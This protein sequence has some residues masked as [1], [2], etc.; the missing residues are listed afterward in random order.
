MLKDYFDFE[1]RENILSAEEQIGKHSVMAP[2]DYR[3]PKERYEKFYTP[4]QLSYLF[5]HGIIQEYTPTG[6][7]WERSWMKKGDYYE[8]TEY[9]KKLRIWYSTSLKDYLYYYVLKLWK[10]KY[11]WQ[12]IMIKFGK[13]Y[14]WQEYA[15]LDISE[16]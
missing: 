15:G 10:I 5:E 12:G 8:F 3:G 13:H 1:L 9:G 14:T 6:A 4:E 7:C 11:W 16:I 2:V